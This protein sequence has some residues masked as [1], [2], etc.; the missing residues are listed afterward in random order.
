MGIT[1]K[2]PANYTPDMG[3]Y[4]DLKPFRFW[5]QKVL[6]LVYDDSL[7]YYEVLCKVVDY[8]NKSMEDV[9]ILHE[10]VEALNTA[11]QQL[12][13][14]VN[15][16]FSTLDVQQEINHK[17][18]VMASDGTLDALLLPYFNAYKT[19]INGIISNQNQRLDDQDNILSQQTTDI[20]TLVSRMDTFAHLTEGSTTADAELIDIRVEADGKIAATAGNAVREQINNVTSDIFDI[21]DLKVFRKTYGYTYDTYPFKAN[22]TYIVKI[23][24]TGTALNIDT[25]SEASSSGSVVQ[26]IGNDK[27]TGDVIT[28]HCTSNAAAVR[29]FSYQAPCVVEIYCNTEGIIYDSYEPFETLIENS[30][31][32]IDSSDIT[33]D[34]AYS[35][36]TGTVIPGINSAIVNYPIPIYKGCT[37]RMIDVYG[38]FTS[39][40]YSDG[41]ISNITSDTAPLYTGD[42]TADQNAEL[43]VTI[44]LTNGVVRGTPTL[45]N[46]NFY[47][48]IVTSDISSLLNLQKNLNYDDVTLGHY[49]AHDS[50]TI[51]DA[52][53]AGILNYPIRIF[54]GNRYRFEQLYAYF[55]PIKYDNGTISALSNTTGILESGEFTAAANGFVYISVSALNGEIRGVPN[56]YNLNIVPAKIFENDSIDIYPNT[57]D[58]IGVLKDNQGKNIHFHAGNYNIIDMYEEH[59]GDDYFD[60]YVNYSTD[61]PF[62]RGINI[63]QDTKVTFDSGADFTCN[64][65]GNNAN[66]PVYF[67]CFALESGVTLSGLNLIASGVRNCIH[68]DFD[69]LHAATTIIENCNL[70]GDQFVI[71]GGLAEHDT[72]IIRNCIFNNTRQDRNYD[73][74]YHNSG[75]STA[76]S[77]LIIKDNYMTK[78]VSIRYYGTSTLI[79]DAIISN[80]RMARAIEYKAETESSEILNIVVKSWNN[81]IES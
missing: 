80:N 72:V 3:S 8:L 67:S 36:S 66:I 69:N 34:K 52:A 18:D 2:D 55:S 65:S 1:P 17:L 22:N 37:Y 19:E 73:F 33:T 26:N 30:F 23:I 75:F 9:G 25:F 29:I 16:Y 79:S 24:S 76:Q 60:N 68:D 54:K 38:Y 81:Y 14:Y 6:P 11:Y 12:Q 61:D 44:S 41:T 70:Q 59:Y 42:F 58:I 35:R 74:S 31:R 32:M 4:T 20:N 78:G 13:Q 77:K 49:Y 39:I 63:F 15:D 5:C 7:S 71:A 51:R 45:Y 40:R 27:H 10:D 53:T 57:S 50:I 28:F 56:F 48:D 43:L 47:P 64:Y 46:M 62:D 21:A